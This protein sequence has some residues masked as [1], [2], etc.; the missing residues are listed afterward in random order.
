MVQAQPTIERQHENLRG[1]HYYRLREEEE[2]HDA[3]SDN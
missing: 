2:P 3:A 1:A